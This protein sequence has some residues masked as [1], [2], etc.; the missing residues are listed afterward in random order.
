MTRLCPVCQ[1]NPTSLNRSY[2]RDCNNSWQRKNRKKKEKDQTY[3]EKRR[4]RSRERYHKTKTNPIAFFKRLFYNLKKRTKE[5]SLPLDLT[6]QFL[7][8]RWKDCDGMCELT[9]IPMILGASGRN[10]YAVSVDRIIPE[11][12]YVKDNVRLITYGLNIAIQD[13]GLEEFKSLSED[14]LNNIKE[15]K[16]VIR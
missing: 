4:E 13:R 5:K 6:W 9:R 1:E 2:C 14:I 15:S 10:R 8:K 12:G 16:D 3:V 11:K 7:L